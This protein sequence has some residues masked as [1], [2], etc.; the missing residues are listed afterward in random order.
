M[1]KVDLENLACIRGED[2][3]EKK[4]PALEQKELVDDIY[5]KK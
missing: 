3:K 5:W 4:I 2:W 1:S